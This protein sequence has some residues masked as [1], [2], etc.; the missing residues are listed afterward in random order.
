MTNLCAGIVDQ[1]IDFT[2]KMRH[3]G[4]KGLLNHLRTVEITDYCFH[5]VIICTEF[6]RGLPHR[7]TA[8]PDNHLTAGIVESL[9]DSPPNAAA[10]AG[11]NCFFALNMK[12][13]INH[14]VTSRLVEQVGKE[15]TDLRN[16]GDQQQ[17]NYHHDKEGENPLHHIL[18]G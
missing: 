15:E 18:Q 9:G 6:L 12:H 1:N 11:H 10:A 5:L 7:C 14:S 8:A 17:Y 2:A 3:G 16:I 13:V 4:L